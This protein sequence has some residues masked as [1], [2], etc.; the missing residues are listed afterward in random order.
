V[1]RRRRERV[2]ALAAVCIAT[3]LAPPAPCTAA[4]IYGYVQEG[5]AVRTGEGDV[6]F[7]RQTLNIKAQEKFGRRLSLRFESNFWVDSPDFQEAEIRAR[8]REG[9]AKLKF[10]NFD[11]RAGRVQ[12]AWGEADGIIIS[13][14]VSPFDLQNFIVPA[15]DEIRLG[16][17]GLFVD[18]YIGWRNVVQVFWISHFTQP[19]F[20]DRRS[21]WSVFDDKRLNKQIADNLP[22]GAPPT[23]VTI[24]KINKPTRGPKSSEGGIRFSSQ[25]STI[26]WQ[27]GYLYSFDDRPNV[28]LR[29]A[30][31]DP[32]TM[33]PTVLVDG[34]PRHNRFHLFTGSFVMPIKNVLFKMDSALEHGRFLQLDPT[35]PKAAGRA[36]NGFV[37]EE[38]VSRT[39]IA[40]DFKPSFSWWQQ[41][42]ASIQYIHESVIDPHNALLQSEHT[43]LFSIRL[44]AAYLNDTVKPWFFAITNARG[45]DTWIQ[46]KLD[47]EPVDRWRFTFEYDW[48]H[49]HADDGDSGGI[50]GRFD[51]NDM[52]LFMMRY[53]Y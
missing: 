49:G 27:M 51:D 46:T 11:V 9:Y 22:P 37:S 4:E 16:V 38:D 43:D 5:I 40:V 48:F 17:D 7:H 39:L 31:L 36:D 14:Q 29:P 18:Y 50:Y 13:D 3:G 47:W 41:A 44:Q 32:D 42:D 24:G 34:Q 25:T 52:F 45:D 33:P 53:S 1:T 26:D 8:V 20:P 28:R 10:K 35:S 21:P 15:F 6:L 23:E 30:G 12:V 19:D 2:T